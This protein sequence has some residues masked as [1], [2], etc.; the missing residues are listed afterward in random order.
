M[1]LWGVDSRGE[2]QEAEN[3]AVRGEAGIPEACGTVLS[4]GEGAEETSE[5]S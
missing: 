4:E 5:E 1:S 2:S 3:P